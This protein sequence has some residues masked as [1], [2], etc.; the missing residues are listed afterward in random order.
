MKDRKLPELCPNDAF[1]M[2][3]DFG[4]EGGVR[5]NHPGNWPMESYAAGVGADQVKEAMK[6]ATKMGVPTEF[7][8]KTGDAIFTS[9]NHRKRY[10]EA[11]GLYDRNGG[12]SDPQKS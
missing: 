5:K 3:R 6:E 7:N 1:V 11:M 4:A 2:K 12:Y 9:A 10:C 8:S